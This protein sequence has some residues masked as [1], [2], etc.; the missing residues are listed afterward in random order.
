MRKKRERE[1]RSERENEIVVKTG[2]EIKRII[3]IISPKLYPI[4]NFYIF[5]AALY[6]IMA[7][8]ENVLYFTNI[9][10]FQ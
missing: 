7:F 1:I 6:R 5:C 2:R 9:L 10:D 3:N 8:I 4:K